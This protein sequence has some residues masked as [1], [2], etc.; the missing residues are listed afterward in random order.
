VT[1]QGPVLD[2]RTYR[3]VPDGRELFDRIFRNEVLPMLQS[4]GIDVVAYGPSLVDDR[5]YYLA[6]A[7]SSEAERDRQLSSFYGSDAW[8][9]DYAETVASI[10]ETFHHLVIPPTPFVGSD[11]TAPYRQTA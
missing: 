7:F 8:R 2:L 6:R 10:V 5:H 9:R 1:A 3:L 11:R 4:R